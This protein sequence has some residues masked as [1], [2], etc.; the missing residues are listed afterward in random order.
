MWP[1]IYILYWRI[2]PYN[3]VEG[4]GSST[5]FIGHSVMILNGD[6][7]A[8]PLGVDLRF[9]RTRGKALGCG[10]PKA[11]VGLADWVLI[12]PLECS[13]NPL[14][15]EDGRCNENVERWP[16]FADLSDSVTRKKCVPQSPC[17]CQGIP[18][19]GMIF[20]LIGF[21][22]LLLLLL[23][24]KEMPWSGEKHTDH[25]HWGS[26]WNQSA[27]CQKAHW[28]EELDLM[29]CDMVSQDCARG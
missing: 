10:R 18:Q 13:T 4:K 17:S 8:L 23:E 27:R 21:W 12:T 5:M 1:S 28:E 22:P 25:Y 14:N 2:S 7:W 20:F 26:W 16:D 24:C 19:L 6:K 3:K 9:K 11:E 29:Q 15:I